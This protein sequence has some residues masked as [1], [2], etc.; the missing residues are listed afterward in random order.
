MGLPR[1]AEV[2]FN[3][4]VDLVTP[5][6]KPTTSSPPEL[7]GLFNFTE[8]QNPPIKPAGSILAAYGSGA[9]NV[10]YRKVNRLHDVDITNLL[11]ANTVARS[12]LP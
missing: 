3:T 5:T 2:R 1:W 8:S 4:D 7:L 9:L 11:A 6:T 10:I 12:A